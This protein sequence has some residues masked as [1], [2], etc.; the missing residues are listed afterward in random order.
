MEKPLR[1]LIREAGK[2]VLKISDGETA[3]DSDEGS[4]IEK[5]SRVMM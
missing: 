2:W 5:R 4:R 1:I 3:E